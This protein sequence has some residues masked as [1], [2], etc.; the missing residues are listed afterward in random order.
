[1]L[2]AFLSLHVG[3]FPGNQ[4]HVEVPGGWRG[5]ERFYVAVNLFLE[6]GERRKVLGVD[7]DEEGPLS[8]QHGAGRRGCY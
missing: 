5:M 2:Q 6:G 3:P 1:M 4:D 7:G 8:F